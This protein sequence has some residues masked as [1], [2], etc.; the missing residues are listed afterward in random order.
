MSYVLWAA[1]VSCREVLVYSDRTVHTAK[2]GGP[3]IFALPHSN[4]L[5][6]CRRPNIYLVIL[7]RCIFDSKLQRLVDEIF[8]SCK[9]KKKMENKHSMKKYSVFDWKRKKWKISTPWS[10][11]RHVFS[12][13]QFSFC[14]FCGSTDAQV[15]SRSAPRANDFSSRCVIIS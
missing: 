10:I 11:S 13:C 6:H 8:R 4:A 2:M 15:I 1:F 12:L 7:R 3:H 9:W 5:N 14:L